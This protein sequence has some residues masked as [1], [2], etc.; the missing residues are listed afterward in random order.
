M[1]TEFNIWNN[2][3]KI[4]AIKDCGQALVDNAESIVGD[5]KYLKGVIITCY[6][7]DPDAMPYINVSTDFYPEGNFEMKE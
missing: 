4:R 5:Y 3:G 7:D 6:V 1:A 2:E